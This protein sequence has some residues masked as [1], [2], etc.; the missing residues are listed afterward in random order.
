MIY[1]PVGDKVLI[2]KDKFDSSDQYETKSGILVVNSE[3][4]RRKGRVSIGTVEAIGTTFVN[5]H[6][7]IEKIS[8]NFS[9]GDKVLY[10][11]PAGIELEDDLILVRAIDIDCKVEIKEGEVVRL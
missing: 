8:D 9:V 4:T 3:D 11:H 10:Y 7:Q 2:R 5:N 1:K 6:N